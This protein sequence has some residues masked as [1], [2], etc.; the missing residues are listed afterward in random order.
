MNA[1]SMAAKSSNAPITNSSSSSAS[2]LKSMSSLTYPNYEQKK[3]YNE[4]NDLN[5]K[6][7]MKD[8][9]YLNKLPTKLKSI[10]KEKKYL[11]KI[12]SG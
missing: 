8:N 1:V 6:Q 2:L 4:V 12:Y 9:N 11:F 3:F 5:L 7:N 10:L